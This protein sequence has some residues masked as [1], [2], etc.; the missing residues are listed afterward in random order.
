MIM[1]SSGSPGDYL[2]ARSVSVTTGQV[3]GFPNA[4]TPANPT[5]PPENSP[6]AKTL[7]ALLNKG[8][9]TDQKAPKAVTFSK[10]A[11][12][13]IE[14]RGIDVESGDVIDRLQK[15]VNLAHE[16]NSGNSLVLIDGNAFLV[17]VKNSKVITAIGNDDVQDSIFTNIDSTVVG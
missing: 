8:T 2:K 10:H 12:Q 6:F 11:A 7:E 13:R 5:E 1:N 14:E 9:E 16:K 3:S 4:Q 17:S 15:A